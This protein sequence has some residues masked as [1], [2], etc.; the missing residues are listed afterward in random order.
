MHPKYGGGT[1]LAIAIEM[2]CGAVSR[3]RTHKSKL[4]TK[5]VNGT[6]FLFTGEGDKFT[7]ST[8]LIEAASY[9]SQM[10]V[11]SNFEAYVLLFEDG[12]EIGREHV[13]T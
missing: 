1:M 7:S 5:N 10:K 9:I 11:W 12:K 8:I 2:P 3:P 6:Q 13:K 4:I